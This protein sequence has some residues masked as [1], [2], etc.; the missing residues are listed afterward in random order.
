MRYGRLRVWV[1]ARRVCVPLTTAAAAG[2]SASEPPIPRFGSSV[3]SI[4]Y[5]SPTGT[6]AHFTVQNQVG[7]VTAAYV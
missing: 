7:P 6:S 2:A 5:S 1:Y 3:R 4:C